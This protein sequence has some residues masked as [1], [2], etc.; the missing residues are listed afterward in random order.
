MS[1]PNPPCVQWRFGEFCATRAAR[2]LSDVLFFRRFLLLRRQ[3]KSAKPG[4]GHGMPFEVCPSHRQNIKGY[5]GEVF[6]ICYV[7]PKMNTS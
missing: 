7:P 6:I 4:K 3:K 5:K 2:R 1:E